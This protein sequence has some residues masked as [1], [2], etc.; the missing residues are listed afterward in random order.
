[1]NLESDKAFRCHI[2]YQVGSIHTVQPDTDAA[3]D[4]FNTILVPIISFVSGTACFIIRQRNQPA[5]TGFVINASAPGTVGRVNFT[6]VAMYTPILIIR[7]AFATE[8]YSGIQAR[9]TLY[10]KFKDE[11]T[12]NLLGCHKT[13]RL[14][15]N[16]FTDHTTSAIR[17]LVGRHH[18]AKSETKPLI[19]NTLSFV[20]DT[21]N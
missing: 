7:P 17:R 5:T 3:A 9:I 4:G 20:F 19:L 15:G 10:F 13:I 1:M 16:G 14:P 21:I 6:L 11:V 2:V 8:L 12:I 18:T